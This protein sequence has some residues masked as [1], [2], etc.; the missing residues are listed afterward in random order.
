MGNSKLKNTKAVTEMLAGVH[1]TQTK[2]T[3]NAINVEFSD[4]ISFL[5]KPYISLFNALVFLSLGESALI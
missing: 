5:N 1:K 3:Y 4:I 2:T